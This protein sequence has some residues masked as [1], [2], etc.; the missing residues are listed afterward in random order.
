VTQGK[1]RAH[2]RASAACPK[3]HCQLANLLREC[4]T[5]GFGVADTLVAINHEQRHTFSEQLAPLVMRPEVL[6]NPRV[7]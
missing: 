2:Y 1:A 5:P 3:W 6:V 4:V 7:W